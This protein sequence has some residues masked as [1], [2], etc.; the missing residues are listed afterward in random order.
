MS[1]N[2]EKPTP[3]ILVIPSWYK[4]TD[5]SPT[6]FFFTKQT[7]DMQDIGYQMGMIYSQ[8][9]GLREL[10][11]KTLK[12]NHFQH[13]YSDVDNFP[14]LGFKGWNLF[15]LLSKQNVHQ[16]LFTYEKLFKK[17]V[18]RF[19]KPD[20]IHA[21]SFYWAGCA[22]EVITRKH[23][24]PFITT[25][26]R[27]RFTRENIKL[28]HQLKRWERELIHNAYRRSSQ[29]IGVSNSILNGLATSLDLPK[30]GL[31]IPVGV[32]SRK[33]SINAC[34]IEKPFTFLTLSILHSVKRTDQ[35]VYA[36]SKVKQ[37][38]PNIRLL[39]GGDGPEKNHLA[40]L[41]NKLDL[42]NDVELLGELPHHEVPKFMHQ[43]DAFV[44][45]SEIESLGLVYIEAM[46]SGLPIIGTPTGGAKSIISKSN[47]VILENHS[48]E[49][50][51]QAMEHFT[52]SKEYYDPEF[53][54]NE[55]I[56]KFDSKYAAKQIGDVYVDVLQEQR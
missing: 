22:A 19:G 2:T 11:W 47:G 3:H 33:F 52:V 30:K 56:Q 34:Q 35:I 9:Q 40:S 10:S 48:V 18:K 36:F 24:I 41:I 50:L 13:Y 44:L 4:T 45:A 6:G 29:V 27:G 32:E 14:L 20:L 42:Q 23:G 51:A 12:E 53:I 7:Q 21:H 25:E 28:D 55:A 54:R 43:G 26:H 39:I 31:V 8:I 46:M 37:T 17:Y 1:I 49:A 15:P 16:L 5:R 38:Y